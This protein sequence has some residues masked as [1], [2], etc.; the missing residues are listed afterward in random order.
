MGKYNK[1]IGTIVGALIGAGFMWAANKYGGSCDATGDC[2][3]FGINS[4]T[5]TGVVM[6]LFAT[7]GTVAA[8]KNT[9]T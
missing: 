5:I 8:P 1:A 3:V 4:A 9:N 2:T 7:A 6:S